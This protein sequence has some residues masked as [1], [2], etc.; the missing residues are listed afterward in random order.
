[1]RTH[2]HTYGPIL[3]TVILL[4]GCGKAAPWRGPTT[5]GVNVT[6]VTETK[7][8]AT[9]SGDLN[10]AGGAFTLCAYL[11]QTA[12]DNETGASVAQDYIDCETVSYNA[13]TW[14]VGTAGNGGK[15]YTWAN[16][17]A[18]TFWAWHPVT[19]ANRSVTNWKN[20]GTLSFSYTTSTDPATQKD[21]LFAKNVASRTFK[22]EWGEGY[23]TQTAQT[24]DLDASKRVN[25][26]FY[27]ALA[28]VCFAL[29]ASD[30]TFDTG[31]EITSIAVTNLYTTG[32]CAF[33][34]G[35]DGF[36]W[37]PG[38][39][40]NST[41]SATLSG[42]TSGSSGWSSAPSGWTAGT[43]GSPAKA[44]YTLDNT[45]ILI[46]QNPG[47]NGSKIR[48]TFK[49]GSDTDTIE[50]ALPSDDWLA[51]RYYKYK[52][53]ATTVLGPID[54]TVTLVDWTDGGSADL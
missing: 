1:M 34:G 32:S 53:G 28:Q 6:G 5:V 48:I 49:R 12:T 3:A 35:K 41:V 38:G 25:I 19:D 20:T 13:G 21:I 37:T 33:T 2:A 9:V 18:T 7:A 26:T 4:A 42:A 50:K 47:T 40:A 52:I 11:A 27:H 43:Y 8:A 22:D 45:F 24:G 14:T 51:G 16:G 15:D 54:F 10:T 44:I 30:G 46:P 29:S 39:S 31:L 17:I 23:G 36:A